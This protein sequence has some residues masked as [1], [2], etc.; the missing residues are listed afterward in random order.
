MPS[1]CGEPLRR[2]PPEPS[3]PREIEPAA[4]QE[5]C[6][7]GLGNGLALSG[8]SRRDLKEG[9]LSVVAETQLLFPV[10][11][12]FVWVDWSDAAL[13]ERTSQPIQPNE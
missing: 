9:Y 3:A 1:S 2:D 4:G 10:L 7:R 13:S 11:Q 12:A 8:A 5:E 6:G